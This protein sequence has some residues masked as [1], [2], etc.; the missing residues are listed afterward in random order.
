MPLQDA[1]CRDMQVRCAYLMTPLPQ[2][3]VEQQ[4]LM[5]SLFSPSCAWQGLRY[6]DLQVPVLTLSTRVLAIA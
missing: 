2:L 5:L 3:I 6:A 1:G 4:V